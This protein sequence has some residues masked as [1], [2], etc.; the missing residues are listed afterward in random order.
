VSADEAL[1]PQ[2]ERFAARLHELG[3][4]IDLDVS[5][6]LVHTWQILIPDCPEAAAAIRR[7][8]LFVSR[9]TA[10]AARG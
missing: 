1:Y 5:A 2:C 9:T 6:G 4:T 3:G 10:D 7:L 8:A